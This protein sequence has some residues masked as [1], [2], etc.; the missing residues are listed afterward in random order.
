M[1]TRINF[2][3]LASLADEQP[4]TLMG[5]IRIAWPHIRAGQR[6]QGHTKSHSQAIE[7]TPGSRSRQAPGCLRCASA[8]RAAARRP[9]YQSSIRSLRIRCLN[10][11]RQSLTL[12]L[13]WPSTRSPASSLLQSARLQFDEWQ[14]AGRAYASSCNARAPKAHDRRMACSLDGGDQTAGY[15]REHVR[16]VRRIS[17][18]ATMQWAEGNISG[19]VLSPGS[20]RDGGTAAYP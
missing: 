6:P 7:R 5:C 18:K 2:P 11:Q 4:S 9:Q 10:R 12:T 13:S 19:D 15:P 14:G 20:E 8:K 3:S 16:I 17:R 1:N